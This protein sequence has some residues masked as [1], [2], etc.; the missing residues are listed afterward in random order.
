MAIIASDPT[1]RGRGGAL[2]RSLGDIIVATLGS[3]LE[4]WS[5]LCQV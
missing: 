4:S 1:G 5:D 2:K 3:R